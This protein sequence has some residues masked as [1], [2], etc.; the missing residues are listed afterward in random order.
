MLVLIVAACA[1]AQEGPAAPPAPP[2]T[3]D[4]LDG[5][6]TPTT[7]Y[8]RLAASI[9]PNGTSLAGAGI[10]AYRFVSTVEFEDRP[11]LNSRYVGEATVMPPAM[12]LRSSGITG[13]FDYLS[14]DSG[15]WYGVDG[16]WVEVAE[17]FMWSPAGPIPTHA[18]A[19]IIG[20]LALRSGTIH[21]LGNETVV[22]MPVR[23]L[24]RTA[25]TIV[26]DVLV[27]NDGLVLG[28]EMFDDLPHV[29]RV[30]TWTIE[31]SIDEFS[32]EPPA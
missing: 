9:D 27:T 8:A 28:V 6:S 15:T 29:D 21:D 22:G 2:S 17:T 7:E 14:T 3:V 32:I 1:P 23:R 24:R 10:E 26:V 16:Q 4:S 12:R 19:S 31:A 25:P 20:R 13:S 30:V 11:A 18:V 5:G